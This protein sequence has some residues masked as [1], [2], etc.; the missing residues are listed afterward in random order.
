MVNAPFHTLTAA[1]CAKLSSQWN[2]QCQPGDIVLEVG[3]SQSLEIPADA[4]DAFIVTT[5]PGS[6]VELLL[7][8]QAPGRS[9]HVALCAADSSALQVTCVVPAEQAGVSIAVRA[10]LQTRA[11]FSCIALA[12]GSQATLDVRC[13]LLGPA[14]VSSVET[15]LY[16]Y[17]QEAQS[18]TVR[19]VFSAPQGGGRIGMRAVAEERAKLSMHGLIEIGESGAGTDTFLAQ[20]VLMLDATASVQTV[21]A[22]EIRTNDVKASHSATVSRITPEDLFYFQSRGIDEAEARRMFI[23]GFLDS[24][25]T[26]VQN[27]DWAERLRLALHRKYQRTA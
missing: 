14:A 23:E 1:D 21:P 15:V 8:C 6:R 9:L 3:E 26:L 7:W 2:V 12:L 13:E 24:A 19:N 22:L 27:Q 20:E 11:Q 16:G 10:Y 18:C 4:P 5:L 25:A 17:G